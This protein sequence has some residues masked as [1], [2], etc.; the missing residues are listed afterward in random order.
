MKFKTFIAD[1]IHGSIGVTE[2]ELDII[3]SYPLQRLRQIRQLGNVHL[4]FP[5]AVHTRFSHSIGVM[6]LASKIFEALFKEVVN[7]VDSD[8]FNLIHQT[9]RLAGLL[10]DVGHGPFSHH[11]EKMMVNS[12]GIRVKY[13]TWESDLKLPRKWMLEEIDGDL[14][15]EHYSYGVIMKLGEIFDDIDSQSICSLLEDNIKPSKKFDA[16]LTKVCHAFGEGLNAGSLRVVLKSIMSSEIDAD[17]IDY[18]MRDSHFCGIEI[19]AID[20]S[21]LLTSIAIKVSTSNE[22]YIAVNRNAVA[23]IEQILVSR[24]HMFDQVYSHKIN[25]IFDDYLERSIEYLRSKNLIGIP[26]SFHEFLVYTDEYILNLMRRSINTSGV[27]GVQ[28]LKAIQSYLTRVKQDLM[29]EEI[30]SASVV[31]RR[32]IE[33]NQIYGSLPLEAKQKEFTKLSRSE[34]NKKSILRVIMPSIKGQAVAP[35][36]LTQASDVIRSSLW[37][38]KMT[39]LLVLKVQDSEFDKRLALALKCFPILGAY[40]VPKSEG[41]VSLQNRQAKK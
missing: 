5:S 25:I 15:H 19:A 39:R 26:L 1:P 22:F 10:H 20:L 41:S 12:R 4:A 36:D 6:H 11:F 28:G 32:K 31:E 8:S 40:E 23:A 14:K 7:K 37:T 3:N 17:R 34:P 33:L 27:A 13:S 38:T 16:A 9:I 2:T 35:M 30:C 18:L 24:K 29:Y 21:H